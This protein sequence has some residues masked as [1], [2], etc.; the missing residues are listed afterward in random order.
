MSRIRHKKCDEKR[1][2]C[3]PCVSTGRK[4]DFLSLPRPQPAIQ[5]FLFPGRWSLQ[6]QL[7]HTPRL[8]L[9]DTWHFEYFR[10]VTIRELSLCMGTQVWSSVILPAAFAEP[11]VLPGILALASLS[12]NMAPS[13]VSGRM[14]L[15]SGYPASYSLRKY[16]Q[17]I[18]ELNSRLDTS[19]QS[20]ELALLGSLIFTVIENLRGRED[21]ARVHLRGAVAI[22]NYHQHGSWGSDL[23]A[24]L[25]Q[26]IVALESSTDF[27]SIRS[28]NQLI[29][30]PLS[31]QFTPLLT[32]KFS[33]I[34]EARDALDM[35]TGA[36]KTLFW[37]Q[38][39]QTPY[40]PS[41][42]QQTHKNGGNNGYISVLTSHLDSWR[43]RFT[44]L[45]ADSTVDAETQTCVQTLLI[46]H[47]VHELCVSTQSRP[48][49]LILSDAYTAQFASILNLCGS[50][51]RAEQASRSTAGSIGPRAG[52]SL[53]DAT[54]QPLF[55]V[56]CQCRNPIV[57]REAIK[58]L[59]QIE[60][61][62]DLSHNDARLLACVAEW[63]VS[64]EESRNGVSASL[65]EQGTLEIREED[66]LHDV[67]FQLD[68]DRPSPSNTYSVSAWRRLDRRW[69]RLSDRI[70]VR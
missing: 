32:S 6:G 67:E 13:F 11:F 35:I 60:S 40:H 42:S 1:P 63:V 61:D 4:C 19:A 41:T 57:R 26:A 68:N 50:I 21:L 18:H 16:N 64:T 33:S 39:A 51:I 28:S 48:A 62:H 34:N 49:S 27:D 5:A 14:A 30:S 2:A 37:K 47:Q 17:S 7:W 46:H 55:F 53:A 10:T 8:H 38:T 45:V 58:L 56:A 54:A 15:V 65:F 22:M 24:D 9:I 59:H 44:Q 43:T 20:R 3:S 66:V 69:V 25:M 31:L 52:H 36:I 29:H 23:R 12:R 70:V